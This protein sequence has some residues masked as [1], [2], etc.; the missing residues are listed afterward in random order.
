M[1]GKTLLEWARDMDAVDCCNLLLLHTG[2]EGLEVEAAKNVE[3]EDGLVGQHDNDAGGQVAMSPQQEVQYQS[4]QNELLSGL[5]IGDLQMLISENLNLIPQLTTCRDDL[6]SECTMCQSLLRDISATGGR[7]ALSSQSLL[8]LVRTLKEERAQAEEALAAWDAAWE[9]REEELSFF[10]EEVLDDMLR[11]E[12][13]V[14]LDQVDLNG[15]VPTDDPSNRNHDTKTSEELVQHFVEV[16]NRVKSLRASIAKLAE[17]SANAAAEIESRGMSGAL[18][19]TRTL[20]EEVKEIDMKIHEASMGE[21]ACRRKIEIIQQRI[22]AVNSQEPSD[23]YE[24]DPIRMKEGDDAISEDFQLRSIFQQHEAS[25]ESGGERETSP[26]LVDQQQ[27]DSPVDKEVTNTVSVEAEHRGQPTIAVTDSLCTNQATVEEVM[28]V[29]SRTMVITD[30]PVDNVDCNGEA[31][32]TS[33]H[34]D[35]G[36]QDTND[37]VTSGQGR[38]PSE[39]QNTAINVQPSHAIS[40]GVSTAIVVHTPA[41]Q[42]YGS[43]SSQIWEIL[44]MIVGLNRAP[45]MNRSYSHHSDENHPHIMVV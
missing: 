4:I 32:V 26:I 11:G 2:E 15:D 14:V 41:G 13:G 6:A 8:E 42:K 28:K 36:K 44:R 10:W 18:S 17:E 9:E 38:T 23:G 39:P 40:Q 3:E 31:I 12:L 16:D 24:A 19:L 21:A 45:V 7:G 1:A 29:E 43:L 37:R 25:I 35:T 5:S 33:K 22:D 27:V 30:S 34:N 20:R